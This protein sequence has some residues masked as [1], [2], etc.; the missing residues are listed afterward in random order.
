MG[1]GAGAGRQV[2]KQAGNKLEVTTRGGP[3]DGQVSTIVVGGGQQAFDT[4]SGRRSAEIVWEGEQIRVVVEGGMEVRR[5]MEA[6][7][8]IPNPSPSPLVALLHDIASS[9]ISGFLSLTLMG[10]R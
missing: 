4:P 1:Y 2:V 10:Y 9:G 5:F 3:K 8:P 6:C 7:R